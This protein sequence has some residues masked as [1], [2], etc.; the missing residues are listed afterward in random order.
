[1][2]RPNAGKAVA[3]K[4]TEYTLGLFAARQ[5]IENNKKITRR[6]DLL[7]HRFVGYIDDLL[8]DRQLIFMK[9]LYPGETPIFPTSTIIAQM[10]AVVAGAEGCVAIAE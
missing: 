3:R 4:L 2:T 7:G 9:E 5:F 10:A 1:V 8:Y 6:E